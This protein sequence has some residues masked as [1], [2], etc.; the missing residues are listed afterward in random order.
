MSARK[1]YFY[2]AMVLLVL[3]LILATT[4]YTF[5]EG[6]LKDVLPKNVFH[7]S[8]EFD[9]FNLPEKAFV[10]AYLPTSNERQT[11]RPIAKKSKLDDYTTIDDQWGKR[12]RWDI[13]NQAD[14]LFNYEFEVEA[15]S[16][17]F[18]LPEST[19]YENHLPDSLSTY[20]MPT[21][22]I[23][24]NHD[25]ITAKAKELRRYNVYF[26]VK[27][28]FDYVNKIVNSGTNQLTDAATT[29]R[30]QRGSCNGK[31]RLFVAL[32]RAQG[33]PARV[34][35]GIILE[36]A[37]KRTSHLWAEIY[38]QGHWIPFDVLNQHFAALPANFLEIHKGD[39]F[40]IT[41]TKNIG[42]DYQFKIRKQYQ[43]ASAQTTGISQLWSLLNIA[44]IPIGLLRG[45]LLL[46]LAGL[47]V[48]IFRNVVGL[49]TFGIFLPALIGLALVKVSFIWGLVAFAAVIVVVSLLHLPLEKLGLLHTPKLVIM[50]TCVVL[51]LLAL[52]GIGMKNNWTS[53]TTAMFLPVIVL[54][55]T[56][57]R[58]AK[59]LVEENLIDALKMLGSTFFIAFL[60]YP[61]F[62]ADLLLGLFLTYP[63]L[64]FSI[65]GIMILLGRWIGFRV[66]E[67]K[68]FQLIT[69]FN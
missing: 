12:A 32:C 51:T 62:N 23:Q 18:S 56:A 46:P 68:R 48:A 50:L 55:I 33:I 63:E 1:N 20:L 4:K 7:V 31:S 34:V 22:V 64:Y 35:G 60:C 57:E 47:I 43:T 65:L 3:P 28:N 2:L 61:I 54:S 5:Q 59:T 49:K 24:S 42:F 67:Y 19:P 66:L 53:L 27:S 38:Y 37:E 45:I 16:I 17:E 6:T 14:A 26:T 41:H 9:M 25:S 40:L 44:G 15:K 52:S 30:R 58:F 39:H 69:N 11:I 29:L 13:K 21:A 8:Y 36:N 10:K